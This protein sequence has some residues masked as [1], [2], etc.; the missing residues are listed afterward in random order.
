MIAAD[1]KF[2]IQRGNIL[3]TVAGMEL[4]QKITP[5]ALKLQQMG[6]KI[7]ATPHTA[8]VF[9]DNGID[10]SV[11]NKVRVENNRPNIIDYI[12][13][14]KLCLV[15]NIPLATNKSQ[16]NQILEDEYLIRRK[17]LEFNI[18]VITNMQ[19]AEAIVETL[20]DLKEEGIEDLETYYNKVTVKSLNDYHG[21]LRENYW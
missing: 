15:I 18:P 3:I 9:M 13:N 10:V 20:E 4:K 1:F 11:L 19:L 7:F 12:L 16:V 14:H 17:A 21:Y 8:D 6:Y 2:P 5:I